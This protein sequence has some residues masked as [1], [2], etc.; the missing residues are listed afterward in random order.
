MTPK[1]IVER[2]HRAGEVIPITKEK[3]IFGRESNCEI[4]MYD[5]GLSRQ[6]TLIERKGN[7]YFISD[8]SSTNGTYVNGSLILTRELKSN[9]LIRMGRVELRFLMDDDGAKSGTVRLVE[10]SQELP[11]MISRRIDPTQLG[12]PIEPETTNYKPKISS[13]VSEEKGKALHLLY[14]IGNL[15]H[16]EKD[17]KKLCGALMEVVVRE[18]KAHRGFL[19]LVNA[20]KNDFE[21]VVIHRG[22]EDDPDKELTLSRT[23]VNESVLQGKSILTNDASNDVRFKKGLSIRLNEIQA[24]M[25]VPVESQQKILGAIYIDSKGPKNYFTERGLQVLTAVGRQAG[26][27]I[28][29]VQLLQ[30]YIEKEK[31]RHALLV[32]QDIQRSLLPREIPKIEGFELIGVSLACEETGGDYFDLIPFDSHQ[33]GIVVGD[34]SGHGIG[35]ALLMATVRAYLRCSLKQSFDLSNVIGNVN[36]LLEQDLEGNQF[37]TLILGK[38]DSTQKIFH[39]TSAGHDEPLFFRSRE[40]TFQEL[41]S[42]GMP[43]GIFAGQNY[44]LGVPIQFQRGDILLISTDGVWEAVNEKKEVFGKERLKQLLI[45]NATKSANQLVNLIYEQVK[46]FMGPCPL[47][48][49]FTLVIL[50]AE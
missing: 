17:V 38:L 47:N 14:E 19:I 36:E 5:Q 27:A 34:V 25:C 23:I 21:P 1:F 8:L 22:P 31:L 9:D 42:T 41:K 45:Q 46:K 28:E 37:V 6:H 29:R 50:K 18:L 32:A 33:F 40:Q 16:T 7:S 13:D 39:Y 35:S 48:D 20:E 3:L 44:P 4:Q 12:L 11:A 2:G 24:V 26:S 49:D 10:R 43:L 15:I 30:H